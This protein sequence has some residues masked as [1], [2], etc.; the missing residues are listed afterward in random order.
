MTLKDQALS[1]LWAYFATTGHNPSERHRVALTAIV[2]T[3]QEMANSFADRKTYLSSCDPGTGKSQAAG[4]FL[5]ALTQSP[6]YASVGAIVCSFRKSEIQTMVEDLIAMGVP[7]SKIA[8]ITSD[9]RYN[10][11]GAGT[12]VDPTTCQILVTTQQRLEMQCQVSF[13]MAEQFHFMGSARRIRI[14]EEGWL[15]GVAN[16]LSSAELASLIQPLTYKPGVM[17]AI[18]GLRVKL[19]DAKDGDLVPVPDFEADLN[20]DLNEALGLFQSRPHGD[21]QVLT[22]LFRLSGRAARVKWDGNAKGNSVLTYEDTLPLDLAPL[23]VLDA[24]GRVRQTY[25]DMEKHR[26]IVV[27]LPTAPKRYDPLTVHV[28][29]TAGSKAGWSRNGEELLAGIVSTI[30]TKPDEKW[31]VVHHKASRGV[32]NL[33]R[34]IAKALPGMTSVDL[35]TGEQRKDADGNAVSSQV[36]FVNWGRHQ[37]TNRWREVPNVILAGTLFMGAATYTALT[38]M[39]QGKRPE[40]HR[41][42]KEDIYLTTLGEHKDLL[43]Q[44]LCRGRVRKLNGDECLPMD[45]YV[46]ASTQSGI[47]G[48][49]RDVFPG[50]HIKRWSPVNGAKAKMSPR[51]VQ[52]IDVFEQLAKVGISPISYKEIRHRIGLKDVS[53]WRQQ[54]ASRE[55]WR[56]AVANHGYV[57]KTLQGS[58][59]GLELDPDAAIPA[60]D[61]DDTPTAAF[62][63]ANLPAPTVEEVASWSATEA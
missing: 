26:G 5:W 2:E 4:R 27:P 56:S 49:L 19:R 31:L 7:A 53:S 16:A 48:A 34:E 50:C 55:E 40:T 57:I 13:E 11:L 59:Q 6:N 44:S 37:A 25:A 32:P 39:A 18:D 41:M 45:A 3:L 47:P 17:D 8:V 61:E 52:A 35:R 12:D 28:W 30:Q 15:P 46:I 60:D 22:A 43:L 38:H 58:Q 14:W 63:L 1:S 51:M 29:Q 42:D 10:R 21:R 9:D 54:A 23:L 33:P 36:E 24:S 20:L 62:D